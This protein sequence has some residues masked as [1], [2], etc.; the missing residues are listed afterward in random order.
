MLSTSQLRQAWAP[1]CTGPFAVVGLFG[2]GAVHVRPEIVPAVNKLNEVLQKYN[3]PT[4]RGDTGAF[5]CLS[6]DT[7]VITRDGWMALRDAVGN[8]ELLTVTKQVGH[9]GPGRWTQAEV[10]SFGEQEVWD[11]VLGRNG[12][13]RTIKATGDHRWYAHTE[14]GRLAEVATA[15]L[16]PRDGRSGHRLAS[17]FPQ[18]VVSR[19]ELSPEGVGAGFVFGDGTLDAQGARANLFGDKDS[20]LE[21]W[22]H[23]SHKRLTYLNPDGADQTIIRGLPRSWKNSVPYD[24]GVGVLLGWL[25]GYFAADGRVQESGSCEI[26]SAEVWRL[27]AVRKAALRLG[28]GT[29]PIT[30]VE[31]VGYGDEATPLYGVRLD[32]RALDA[33]FFLIPE[34]RQRWTD[35]MLKRP[36]RRSEWSV[37]SVTQTGETE[38]V[39]CAVVPETE[40]FAVEDFILTGN[41]RKITGGTGYSL[42][43]YGIA[44][45]ICWN[46]NPYGPVLKTDMPPAMVDEILAIRTN[47]GQQVWGWGGNYRGNKDAMHFEIVCTPGDIRT[48]IG[49]GPGVSTPIPAP[50]VDQATI[51]MFRAIQISIDYARLY[52]Q[53]NNFKK[54]DGGAGTENLGAGVTLIQTALNKFS[55]TLK[56]HELLCAVT[57][58][59]VFDQRTE[60]CVKFFQV[61]HQLPGT[62]IVDGATFSRMYS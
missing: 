16:V 29:G 53:Y 2:G 59:G 51:D 57:P 49:G 62:G 47:N 60:D 45:D 25:A 8:V 37:L 13:T 32:N 38:E 58:S 40:C 35:A 61:A 22:F 46:T 15:D 1:P 36:K 44:L 23:P 14:G 55:L 17:V 41:C 31:R 34:H 3:Y 52:A 20:A 43:A 33:D 28:I 9:G 26:N 27:E 19:T 56:G 12:V 10:R 4:R 39:F 11:V 42:H 48:G 54:G 7:L 6:G 5:N 21:Q 24:E 18:S 30:S 50:P